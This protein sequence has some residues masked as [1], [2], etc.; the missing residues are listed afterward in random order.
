VATQLPSHGLFLF[1]LSGG[2]VCGL[3]WLLLAWWAWVDEDW[4][5]YTALMMNALPQIAYGVFEATCIT[6]MNFAQY[7]L[8]ATVVQLVALVV[9]CVIALPKLVGY[10]GE[11]V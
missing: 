3:V 5:D 7:M 1:Y 9:A 10:W 4:E 2:V 6:W 8:W 11:T